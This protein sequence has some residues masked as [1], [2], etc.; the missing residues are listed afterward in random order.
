MQGSQALHF[1]WN[2]ATQEL[3]DVQTGSLWNLNGECID[4][5]LSGMAIQRIQ[6]YQEFWHSWQTFHPDTKQ[7]PE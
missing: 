5:P 6:S 7:Y 3:R 1:T 2:A 4:G